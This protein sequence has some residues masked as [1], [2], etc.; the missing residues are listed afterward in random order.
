M[1]VSFLYPRTLQRNAERGLII[2][3]MHSES[4]MSTQT[5]NTGFV[6]EIV[7]LL[8]YQKLIISISRW[9]FNSTPYR[10]Y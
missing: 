4:E 5:E 10:Y 7:D 2:H 8:L 3:S 9:P 6:S 1:L